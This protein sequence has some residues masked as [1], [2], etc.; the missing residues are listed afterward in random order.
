MTGGRTPIADS[1]AVLHLIPTAI[2]ARFAGGVVYSRYFRKGLGLSWEE[3]FQ[4]NDRRVVE[5]Y[6]NQHRIQ[7]TWTDNGLRTV[8]RR[9]STQRI[10]DT[11]EEVWFNQANLFHISA[12]PTKIRETLLSR[13]ASEDLPRNAYL[14]DGSAIPEEYIMQISLAYEKAGLA[15]DWQAS[16]IMVLNNMLMAHGREPYGGNR[17]I[18]V[19]MT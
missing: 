16:D 15:L 9:P 10:P 3:A 1:R 11:G 8:H 2:R 7:F 19:A 18:L 14:G 5:D 13:F 12:L 17:Q 4:T 6:C